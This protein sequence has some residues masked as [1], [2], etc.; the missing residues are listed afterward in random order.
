MPAPPKK[1][2]RSRISILLLI[3]IFAILTPTVLSAGKNGWNHPGLYIIVATV[4]FVIMLLTGIR[5]TISDGK[6]YIKIWSISNGSVHVADITSVRRSYNP[7]SSPAASL[8]RLRVGLRVKGGGYDYMLISPA[9]EQEFI[10][11]VKAMNP[12]I[13]VDVPTK[14]T[15]WRIWDWDV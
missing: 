3:S 12:D 1:V 4:G 15:I 13:V 5:Y 2:F 14:S 11:E 7:L 8:K 9:R 6:I 10:E